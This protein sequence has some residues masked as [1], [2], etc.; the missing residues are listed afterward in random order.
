M[1][2][3]TFSTFAAPSKWYTFRLQSGILF[4]Y[5]LHT[6]ALKQYVES[7]QLNTEPSVSITEL[8]NTKNFS[9]NTIPLPYFYIVEKDSDGF[10]HCGPYLMS[11][12]HG[13]AT[14]G[15]KV[16]VVEEE[17]NNKRKSDIYPKFAKRVKDLKE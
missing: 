15:K 10:Y 8:H 13:Q 3:Q 1:S 12:K 5:Y 2:N 4:D 11:T 9:T 16:I 17:P 6:V 7:I 14:E